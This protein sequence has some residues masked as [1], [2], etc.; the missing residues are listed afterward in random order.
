MSF[1]IAQAVAICKT[2][3]IMDQYRC[4]VFL[5]LLWSWFEIIWERILQCL[6]MSP[7]Y[8][9]SSDQ[10]FET[11]FIVTAC[12]LKGSKSFWLTWK[13]WFSCISRI[14]LNLW[15]YS[16]KSE[17]KILYNN[18][19]RMLSW[20]TPTLIGSLLNWEIW[21]STWSVRFIRKLSIIMY[22]GKLHFFK[23]YNWIFI[24]N[25]AKCFFLYLEEQD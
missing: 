7:R 14:F 6:S 16:D 8:I 18:G 12:L 5:R 1:I 15:G 3:L 13:I 22:A 2:L 20:G 25:T 23:Y 9:T 19:P 4:D 10:V 24:T 11:S 21:S 17:V